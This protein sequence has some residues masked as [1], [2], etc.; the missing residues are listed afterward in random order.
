MKKTYSSP[1]LEVRGTIEDITQGAGGRGR[2]DFLVFGSVD[3]VGNCRRRSCV[4]AS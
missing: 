4:I 2:A 3:P 1:K